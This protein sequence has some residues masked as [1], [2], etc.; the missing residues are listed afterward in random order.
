MDH[1]QEKTKLW[2][3]TG[4][5]HTQIYNH[6]LKT[7]LLKEIVDVVSEYMYWLDN[8]NWLDKKTGKCAL[9]N[10]TALANNGQEKLIHL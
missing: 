5:D 7:N 1:N 4:T 6:T 8:N 10:N 2:S 9:G 3:A